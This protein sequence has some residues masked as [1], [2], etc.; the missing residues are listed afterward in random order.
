MRAQH[1]LVTEKFGIKHIRLVVG[2]SMGALQTFHWG[3]LYP[4]MMDLLAPF[5]GSAK[6]SRH[7]YVFLEGARGRAHGGRRLEGGLVHRQAGPRPA[8]RRAGLCRPGLSQAFYREQLDIKTMGY[9]SLED[10]RVA[11]WEGFFLP[12]R[13]EQS[14]HHAVD[15]AERRYQRQ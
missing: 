10:F 11:F 8:C 13:S 15:L 14:A 9:S 2:W 5:C 1:R 3:A 12:K 6:C 4:D 7:N